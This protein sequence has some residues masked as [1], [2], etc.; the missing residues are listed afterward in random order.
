MRNSKLLAHFGA[1][2]ARASAYLE[3]TDNYVSIEGESSNPNSGSDLVGLESA[4]RNWLFSKDMVYMLDGPEQREAEAEARFDYQAECLVTASNT[5]HGDK[6]SIGELINALQDFVGIVNRLDRMKK[7]LF[8]GRDYISNDARPSPSRPN[9]G[10]QAD[11]I[12]EVGTVADASTD[13]KLQLS[14]NEVWSREK[15]VLAF[16]GILGLV[17]ESCELV[18][19]WLKAYKF[20]EPLDLVNL[21]EET[22]DGLWYM[23][24]LLEAIGSDFDAEMRRNNRKLRSRFPD[25]FTE[26][27]ANNRD[28]GTERAILEQPANEGIPVIGGFLVP[29]PVENKN[30]E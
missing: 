19:A 5:F 13:E 4:Q 3:P 22:G 29:D 23:A 6:V 16:H 14:Y 7:A 24:I 9:A 17:T 12:L 26:Y 18:E 10:E 11:R 20:G 30:D 8:Y 2:Q 28:L 25:G 27:D 21:G 15:A 1:M